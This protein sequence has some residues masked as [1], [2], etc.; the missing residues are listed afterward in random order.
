MRRYIGY[1]FIIILLLTLFIWGISQFIQPLLP[2]NVNNSV[3]LL[4]VV[5]LAVMSAVANFKDILELCQLVFRRVDHANQALRENNATIAMPKGQKTVVVHKPTIENIPFRPE[6]QDQYQGQLA[7]SSIGGAFV[8][9]GNMEIGRHHHLSTILPDGNVLIAGGYNYDGTESKVLASAELYCPSS[10][11]FAPQGRMVTRR[12]FSA[13]TLLANNTVLITGGAGENGESLDTAELYNP[14]TDTFS[15]VGRMTMARHGHTATLLRNGKVLIAGGSG[16]TGAE[17]YD[18][19]QNTFTATGSMN[20]ARLTEHTPNAILLRDGRVLIAGGYDGIT[21]AI[22]SI[23]IYDPDKGIFAAGGNMALKRA[24]HTLVQLS[25]DK[26]L[27][28]GGYEDSSGHLTSAELYDPATGSVVLIPNMKTQH[29]HHTATL[30]PDGKV[31][32]VGG[33]SR[34]VELYDPE[35]N[36][37]SVYGDL[38]TSRYLHT[39]I[40]LPSG[41]VLLIG[42]ANG[43]HSLRSVEISSV[44]GA[45]WKSRGAT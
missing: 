39:A 43:N 41:Q 3:V 8:T 20:I 14:T 38:A 11:T 2:S 21:G 7:Q 1:A 32:V 37:F 5:F 26:V 9:V 27:I 13:A 42:G 6:L 12:Y 17:I 44:F 28:A 15:L 25:N 19:I 24:C 10:N 23:E 45:S 36:T 33:F 22:A 29:F 4:F 18:P 16:N 35:A 40:L 31:L 30:L 34:V